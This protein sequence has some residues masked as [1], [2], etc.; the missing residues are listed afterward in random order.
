L[1]AGLKASAI[2]FPSSRIDA[3]IAKSMLASDLA[4]GEAKELTLT[5]E[6]QKASEK[7]RMAAEIWPTNP[8]LKDLR[9]MFMD[10]NPR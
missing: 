9:Q 4:L 7:I 8:K 6:S 2:D 10:A 3:A 1:S 5:R